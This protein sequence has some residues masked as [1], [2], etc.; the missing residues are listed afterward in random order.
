MSIQIE[1]PAGVLLL[2]RREAESMLRELDGLKGVVIASVD[3][4]DLVSVVSGEA[5]AKRVAAMASSIVAIGEVVC[6][7]ADLG[8]AESMMIQS[9][10]GFA[11]FQSV[12]YQGARLLVTVIADRRAILAQVNYRAVQ[13][14]RM[15]AA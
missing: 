10:D 11:V 3:G 9:R 14:G 12:L 4:F 6:Q 2:V 7:E 8:Q 5:D 1:L 15:L 13:L